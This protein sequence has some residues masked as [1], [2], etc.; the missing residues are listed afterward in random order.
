M[1]KV[2]VQVARTDRY[3]KGLNV[4]TH[5][6]KSGFRLDK[7]KPADE[8]DT[9]FCKKGDTYY[10]WQFR[11]GGKNFSTTRPR[12]SQLTQSEFYSAVY[13]LQ[14]EAD[15]WE[16]NSEDDFNEMLEHCK[17]QVEEIR[18]YE[19]EKKSNMESEGLENVPSYET[20]SERY[21]AMEEM[22]SEL[23]CVEWE[24]FDEEDEDEEAYETHCTEQKEKITE[25][26]GN[27]SV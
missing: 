8:N 22:H 24:D 15:D 25:A 9:L 11:H 4:P 14:E 26:L 5:K 1:P 3:V 7:S 21:D 19:E 23:E 17:S 12:P 16:V 2:H 27:L 10:W 13:S 20:V 6:T 18:D